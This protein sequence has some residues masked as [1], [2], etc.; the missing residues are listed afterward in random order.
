VENRLMQEPLPAV[1]YDPSG[2][3]VTQIDV[4]DSSV[5]N[6]RIHFYAITGQRLGTY[7]T[8]SQ[9]S[10]NL[11][12]GGK[13]V[14]S[15]GVTVATDRL[16]S[17]RANANGE[18]MAYWPYGGERPGTNGGTTPD[19]RE[20][21]GTYFRDYIGY[22]GYYGGVDYADQRYYSFNWGRFQTPDPLKAGPNGWNLQE[23]GSWNQYVYASD[24]PVN[25]NDPS[26]LDDEGPPGQICDLGGLA[27]P[28]VFCTGIGGGG[29]FAMIQVFSKQAAANA[30]L[31]TLNKL[32]SF[33][34]TLQQLVDNGNSSDC[35]ALADFANFASDL[36][37]DAR[38]FEMAFGVL[39][40]SQFPVTLIPGVSTSAGDVRLNRNGS[41]SG[42]APQYQDEIPNADQAH[43]FAAFFQLGYMYG[44]MVGSIA[45]TWWEKLEGTA[46]NIGDID[47]D[48]GSDRSGDT[49]CDTGHRR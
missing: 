29:E 5:Q 25:H 31:A 13:L 10:L 37:P 6:E 36:A 40:P 39:T 9:S 43:H 33:R 47:P 45:A 49:A 41:P 48:R 19:G 42:F 27:F 35:D 38:S 21:F 34:G 3:R 30:R 32:R 16:G 26:G 11:Y 15:A 12:F 17:V 18:R 20:E 23:P 46:G 8:L 44:S 7:Y 1:G 14:R 2:K 24:D 28:I 4:V 22:N